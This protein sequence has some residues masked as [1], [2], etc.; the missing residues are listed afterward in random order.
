M[1]LSG[2]LRQN[3]RSKGLVKAIITMT[4]MTKS[5]SP[6]HTVR[7]IN[8]FASGLHQLSRTFPVISMYP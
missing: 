1:V 3:Q 7:N 4:A 8:V 5:C 6:F 2:A